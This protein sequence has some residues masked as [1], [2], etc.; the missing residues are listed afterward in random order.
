MEEREP[1]KQRPAYHHGD[2][3]AALIAAGTEMLQEVGLEKLSLRAIAARVG[4]SHTAPKN[5]FDGLRGLLS[6][7]AAEG[8][9]KHAAAMTAGIDARASPQD[10]LQAASN[11]YVAFALANPALFRLMFSP[12]L[13]DRTDPALAEAGGESYAVLQGICKGLDWRPAD[14]SAPTQARTEMML[15]SMVHGYAHLLTSDKIDRPAPQDALPA[16]AVMPRFD[17]RLDGG[18]ALPSGSA[19]PA[20]N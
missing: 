11:G 16:S 10:R 12:A 1:P 5:H 14:G 9:R 2:L 13:L 20:A 6:A 19:E 7:I 3:R 18:D 15:W 4:V 17:Y 8:F